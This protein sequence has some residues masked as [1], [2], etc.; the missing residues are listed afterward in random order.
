M[1]HAPRGD[2]DVRHR[3]VFAFQVDG[4][5]RFVS[6][7]DMLRLFRR[8]LARAEVPMRFSQGF[9]PHPRMSLPLPR[10]VGMASETEALMIETECDVDPEDIHVA[11]RLFTAFG[12]APFDERSQREVDRREEVWNHGRTVPVGIRNHETQRELSELVDPAERDHR[13][14]DHGGQR[15]DHWGDQVH[16]PVRSLRDH[17]LLAEEL[18]Y[19]GDGMEEADQSDSRDVGAVRTDAVLHDRALLALDPGDHGSEGAH[20]DD[21]DE[22]RLDHD[23]DRP[24]G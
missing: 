3:W 10:P 15:S 4:D 14:R 21:Q 22:Q 11:Y 7:H 5:L 18:Q 19:V 24:D 2:P 17:V 12:N 13:V 16:H 9:N 6:H 20:H 23:L 1:K 8:A